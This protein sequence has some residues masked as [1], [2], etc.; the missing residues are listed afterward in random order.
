MLKGVIL[1]QKP[2]MSAEIVLN[3]SHNETLDNATLSYTVLES[4][5]IF[6]ENVRAAVL[7]VLFR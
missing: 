3:S 1:Q 2:L 4:F 7:P 5:C 6:T